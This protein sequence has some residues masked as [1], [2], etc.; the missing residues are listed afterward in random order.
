[1]PED[2]E[3][4]WGPGDRIGK[5]IVW[6]VQKSGYGVVLE[7]WQVK[8]CEQHNQLRF[9]CAFPQVITRA[10]ASRIHR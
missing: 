3:G 10:A 8:S 6:R 4:S 2:V 5:C 1:M 9:S 7:E